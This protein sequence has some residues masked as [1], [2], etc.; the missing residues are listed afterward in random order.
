LEQISRRQ[1]GL[2]HLVAGH[3]L[4]NKF[5]LPPSETLFKWLLILANQNGNLDIQNGKLRANNTPLFHLNGHGQPSA[6]FE[7]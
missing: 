5:V 4:H 3:I 7:R 6:P 1:S 2:A